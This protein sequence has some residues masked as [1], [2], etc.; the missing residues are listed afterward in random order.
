M[1]PVIAWIVDQPGWAYD[2]RA[3][4]I[5]ACLPQYEHRI[6]CYSR[7]G[8]APIGGADLIVCPD[9]RLFQYFPASSRVV[10]NL[11]AVKIFGCGMGRRLTNRS[12]YWHL[13]GLAILEAAATRVLALCDID[14]KGFVQK[15][16]LVC[17]GW[18]RSFRYA[19]DAKLKYQYL[20]AVRHM[21]RC[22]KELCQDRACRLSC[23]EFTAIDDLAEDTEFVDPSGEIGLLAVDLVDEMT[24]PENSA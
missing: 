17:E 6:V 12:N 9:P 15:D 7:V 16:E 1:K 20:H 14:H 10:L 19:T 21:K 24:K 22:Y 18:Y 5:A 13:N 23:M 8:L 2:N 11:N 4:G 3:G